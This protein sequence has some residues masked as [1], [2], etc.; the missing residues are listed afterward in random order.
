MTARAALPIPAPTDTVF[1]AC[2]GGF[3]GGE[4]GVAVTSGGEILEWGG[5]LPNL[6]RAYR[7]VRTD[8]AAAAQVFAELDRIR[9]RSVESNQSDNVTCYVELRTNSGSH[10]VAWPIHNEPRELHHAYEHITDLASRP[11]H[12]RASNPVVGV[13]RESGW[14][15][16]TPV[17]QLPASSVDRPI[18]SLVFALDGTFSVTWVSHGLERV[19]DHPEREM[20]AE[21][22]HGYHGTYQVDTGR[23]SIAMHIA[24]GN[25]V[26]Q[27]FVG[28]GTFRIAS[29]QL[30]L[31]GLH[32]GTRQATNR[33]EICELIFQRY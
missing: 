12:S 1:A 14:K 22:Y 3:S 33:P 16:C 26:P 32:L 18:D 8:S 25:F 27:D 2:H 10:T 6:P 9:F 29:G 30:V 4:H 19:P 31:V 23:R 20:L 17:T 28:S 7:L 15:L 24:G 21:P 13:W 5:P 11:T